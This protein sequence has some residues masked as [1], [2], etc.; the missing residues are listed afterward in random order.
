[1]PLMGNVT[2]MRRCMDCHTP[3]HGL[4][5]DQYSIYDMGSYGAETYRHEACFAV[6]KALIDHELLVGPFK[7]LKVAWEQV[8]GRF[9]NVPRRKWPKSYLEARQRM[10]EVRLLER[11]WRRRVR[12]RRLQQEITPC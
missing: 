4:A 3:L 12:A 11:A 2:R 6:V 10:V 8:T 1:M 9:V 5:A 7:G